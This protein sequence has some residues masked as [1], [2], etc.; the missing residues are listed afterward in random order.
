MRYGITERFWTDQLKEHHKVLWSIT[1]YATSAIVAFLIKKTQY[2][3]LN[4]LLGL[5]AGVNTILIIHVNRKFSSFQTA[6]RRR[7]SRYA[8]VMFISGWYLLAL[9]GTIAAGTLFI[10][11]AEST[12]GRLNE[13]SFSSPIDISVLIFGIAFSAYIFLNE[14]RQWGWFYLSFQ[15]PKDA[16]LRHVARPSFSV[17]NFKGFALFE[18]YV[19][20][21]SFYLVS[22]VSLIVRYTNELAAF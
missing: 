2:Q 17:N 4:V 9:G 14:L 22:I 15:F 13:V 1:V 18:L 12:H 3:I 20:G 16:Y 10:R 6:W 7:F 21:Y 19:I 11:F 5:Y 8:L